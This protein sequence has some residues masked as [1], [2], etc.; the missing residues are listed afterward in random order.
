MKVK[1]AGVL[2]GV[3]L[4]GL[5]ASPQGDAE[6][7]RLFEEKVAP[8][9]AARCYKCHSAEAPKPKG[10]LRVDSREA[11]L[12]GGEGGPGLVPGK[13]EQSLILRAVNWEDPDLQMPPKERLPAAEIAI[14]RQWIARGAPWSAGAR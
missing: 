11:I 9:L 1:A 2:V 12:K 5:S 8:L 10:A 4:L 13:P 14:L 3:L 7:V 6:G